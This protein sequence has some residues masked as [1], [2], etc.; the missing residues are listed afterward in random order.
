MGLWKPPTKVMLPSEFENASAQSF[1]PAL[2]EYNGYL[3]DGTQVLA[4]VITLPP[5]EA[6]R[7]DHL[8]AV[9]EFDADGHHQLVRTRLVREAED[10]EEFAPPADAQ[11]HELVAQYRAAG[12]RPGDIW[13]RPFL[14]E[15]NGWSHGLVYQ[16]DGEGLESECEEGCNCEL[17]EVVWFRPFW[18]PF[19]PPFDS[20]S[21]YT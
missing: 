8:I 10:G 6:G 19:R 9:H 21:Y 17:E 4:Y 3:P 5:N 13:V 18:F 16:A 11:L 20:G 12:W 1:W 2:F 7:R 15:L 14:V